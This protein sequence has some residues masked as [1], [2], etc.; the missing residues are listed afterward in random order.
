M[1]VMERAVDYISKADVLIVGGT[2]LAVI[3]G[4]GAHPLLP[5]REAGPHQQ[6]RHKATTAARLCIAE[7]IGEVLGQ[8]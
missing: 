6:E 3:P 5:W 8:L 7:P 2:S 1:D 4:G